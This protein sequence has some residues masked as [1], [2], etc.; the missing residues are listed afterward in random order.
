MDI[1]RV[2]G[3]NV[4]SLREAQGYSQEELAKKSGID[5]S[6]VGH[7]ERGE[8]NLSVRNLCL[9]AAALKVHP[10]MLFIADGFQWNGQ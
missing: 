2:I 7:V 4:R 5:R 9:I 1:F 3:K 10:S 8:R 6:Y